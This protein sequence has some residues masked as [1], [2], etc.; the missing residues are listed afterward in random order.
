MKVGITMQII[1]VLLLIGTMWHLNTNLTDT[2][3]H[4]EVGKCYD[5]YGSELID[6]ECIVKVC[7]DCGEGLFMYLVWIMISFMLLLI[8]QVLMRMFI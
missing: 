6:Q 7:D 4:E 8:G 3:T 5:K 1:G 2:T